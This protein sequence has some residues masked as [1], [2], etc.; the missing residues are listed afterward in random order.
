MWE[1]RGEGSS[2]LRSP[3]NGWVFQK[4]VPTLCALDVPPCGRRDFIDVLLQNEDGPSK[5]EV[6]L[7]EGWVC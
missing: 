1:R 2:Q 7:D 5:D 6:V 4:E 3:R